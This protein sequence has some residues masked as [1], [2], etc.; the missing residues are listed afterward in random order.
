VTEA[1]ELTRRELMERAGLLGVSLA[2]GGLLLGEQEAVAQTAVPPALLVGQGLD[3]VTVELAWM[4]VGGASAYRVYRDGSLLTEQSG[5]RYDDVSLS[6][7]SRHL[8]T[9]SAVVDGV[10]SAPTAEAAVRTQ[11][12]RNAVAPTTPGAIV[13]TQIT[14]SS[15][16]LDWP[17]STDDVNICGYRVYRGPGS[18]APNQLT[19]IA[20]TDARTTYSAN[21][22]QSDTDY[23]FGAAALDADGNLSPIQTVTFRTA[24][25]VDPDPPAAPSS[26]SVVATA[27]S[28]SRIDLRWAISSSTDV[29]GYQVYR[30]GVL[31]GT[32]ELPARRTFSDTGLAPSQQYTYTIRTIDS[33]G[34]L[35]AP[36][37][38]RKGTT[39]AAGA[40]QFPR[41]PYIQWATPDSVRIA[42]WTNVPTPSVV[43]YGSGATDQQVL[44]PTPRTQHMML[45]GGLS[46]S[47]QYQYRVGDGTTFTATFNFRTA[48]RRGTPFSFAVVGDFGGGSPGELNVANA[49]GASG[50][51]FIQTAGDNVY[52]DSADPDFLNFYSD[53][54]SRF[55]KQ[56][57]P[58]VR[59]QAIWI[60][61][62]NKEYYGNGAV[63]TNFWMPNN[64][65]WYSY[66]W[67]DARVLVLDSEQPYVSGTPQY[68]F[69]RATL[70]RSRPGEHRIV[71]IHRPPYSSAT[72][73]S[74]SEAVQQNLIPLF[75][76]YGV[77]LVLSG[78]THNYERTYP[79]MDGQVGARGITYVVTG[80]GGNG[81]S[82]FTIP[83]PEWS[84]VRND[85]DY[86]FTRVSVS[87]G[88]LLVEAI[89]G[90]TGAVFDTCTIP[91]VR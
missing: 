10:E 19:Y 80:G 59:E 13:V 28:S 30:D 74:S 83:Q 60:A 73:N 12:A 67:G 32:I 63:A 16:Q 68:Q 31:I 21:N 52:P 6:P 33:A 5:T 17:L 46:T 34:N 65:R 53:Y 45:I 35:S 69:A 82:Q 50:T 11:A 79:L 71:I 23:K 7:R 29:V 2:T 39:L 14:E 66:Q 8:Y 49:I 47:S 51:Q 44:D 72:A 64:K 62:G 89:R 78:N 75:Q 90:D 20:T 86:Q 37:N 9:V 77:T 25:V 56:Y 91:R 61:N 81:V 58:V 76:A 38:G 1:A 87:T 22:L 15:A 40:V 26:S 36:T 27:F 88:S 85:T 57:G 42:W 55:Y 84:A 43:Q 70:A 54:D 41:G 18:A 4:A 24:V 3:D 48:A